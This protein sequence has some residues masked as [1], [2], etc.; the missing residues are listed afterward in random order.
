M[1]F[2]FN[3]FFFATSIEEAK[4]KRKRESKGGEDRDRKR[5]NIMV[6][7]LALYLHLCN[8]IIKIMYL[9][10]SLYC[11]FLMGVYLMMKCMKFFLGVMYNV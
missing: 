11:S 10:V 5:N 3:S 6:S 9:L 2:F 7:F 8:N 1:C 4:K